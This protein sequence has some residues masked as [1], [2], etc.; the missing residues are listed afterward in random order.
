MIRNQKRVKILKGN[1]EDISRPIE[2]KSFGSFLFSAQTNSV[3]FVQ[4]GENNAVLLTVV[5]FWY[6]IIMITY[7][8]K[9]AEENEKKIA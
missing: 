6:K 4:G 8:R 5:L 1:A 9:G 7:Q 3:G 2:I